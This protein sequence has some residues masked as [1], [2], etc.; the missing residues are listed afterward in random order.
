MSD[1]EEVISASCN[2]LYFPTAPV[3]DN[4]IRIEMSGYDHRKKADW[5]YSWHSQKFENGRLKKTNL[6]NPNVNNIVNSKEYTS[7]LEKMQLSY[8]LN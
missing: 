2:I 6:F 4:Q 5:S 7:A 1:S 3:K 8:I